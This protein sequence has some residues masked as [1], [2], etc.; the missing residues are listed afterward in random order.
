MDT[1]VLDV[2]VADEVELDVDVEVDEDFVGAF[3]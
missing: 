2:G 3:V 1:C